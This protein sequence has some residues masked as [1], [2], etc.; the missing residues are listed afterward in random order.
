MKSTKKEKSKETEKVKERYEILKIDNQKY[1]LI[2]NLFFF[3]ITLF[4]EQYAVSSPN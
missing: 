2:F 3:L 4:L 1:I